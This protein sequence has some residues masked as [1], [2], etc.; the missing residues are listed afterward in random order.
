M[1][2]C[3]NEAHAH[4]HGHHHGH[5]HDHDHD[6]DE[7]PDAGLVH[8][9]LYQR[10]DHDNVFCLNEA[11]PESG[12]SVLK[13][14]HEKMDDTKVRWLDDSFCGASQHPALLHPVT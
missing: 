10:I 9:S 4:G 3:H 14:W 12:K 1:S 8:E 6:H 11:E 5:D 13:P 7:S 2:H